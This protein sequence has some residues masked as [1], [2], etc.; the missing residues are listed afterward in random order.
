MHGNQY[1]AGAGW[2]RFRRSAFRALLLSI[3]SAATGALFGLLCG[4]ALCLT[5]GVA[6]TCAGSWSL[7]GASAGLAAGA[8]M[9]TVREIYHCNAAPTAPAVKEKIMSGSRDGTPHPS[10]A[11]SGSNGTAKL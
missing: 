8:I 1:H 4:G 3:A 5:D 11:P 9:G 10:Q 2:A 7:R 6:W